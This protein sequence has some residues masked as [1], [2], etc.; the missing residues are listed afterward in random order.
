MLTISCDILNTVLNMKNITAIWVRTVVSVSVAYPGDRGADWQ[1]KLVVIFS[2][3]IVHYYIHLI[4]IHQKTRC[5]V[6]AYCGTAKLV[7]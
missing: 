5:L 4:T 7:H 2:C 1:L 6:Y 3:S